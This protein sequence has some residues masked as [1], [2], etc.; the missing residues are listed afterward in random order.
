MSAL[1]HRIQRP[2]EHLF[3]TAGEMLLLFVEALAGWGE[4]FRAPGRLLFQ[5]AEMGYRSLPLAG[6]MG[7]FTGMVL[8]LQIAIFN[9]DTYIAYVGW[10]VGV[11][12]VSEFGPVFTAF[13]ASGRVGA[14]MTA[15]ISTMQVTEEIDALR[16]MGVSPVRFLVTP[17]VI[18]AMIMLPVLTVFCV[19]V[20]IMGG[21]M[22]ST[23][24]L[25]TPEGLFWNTLFEHLAFIDFVR[26][27]LKSFLF[28]I[29]I[30]IV[31]CHTGLRARGG[32]EGVGR[33][34]TRRADERRV[35]KEGS[36]RR[37]PHHQKKT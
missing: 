25:R 27:L 8:C 11:S 29:V 33:A 36:A 7:L 16:S 6:F 21:A 22:V 34:T 26:C 1:A 23:T 35:G 12:M 13:I 20:G 9:P 2:F 24:Y 31:G 37:S 14:A 32:A 4:I 5:M 15:E 19:W 30:A 3:L 17:R 18:A 28:G 10:F